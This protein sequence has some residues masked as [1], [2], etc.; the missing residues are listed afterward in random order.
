MKKETK[1]WSDYAQESFEDALYSWKG[2]RY[3]NTCFCC[4]Q[5]LEKILKAILTEKGILPPKSHDLMRLAQLAKIKIDPRKAEELRAITRHYFTVR[6]PDLNKKY[7]RSKK[8]TEDTI[9]Q[10]K[11]FYLWFQQELKK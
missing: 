10:T 7:Y 5:A 8:V 11:E 4:Q 3:G 2:H 1:L 9:K 6:Y